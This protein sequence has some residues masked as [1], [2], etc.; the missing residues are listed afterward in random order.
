M[1]IRASRAVLGALL[2]ITTACNDAVSNF[3]STLAT[4]RL[5]NDTD[6]PLSIANN[7]IFD[8]ANARLLFGQ[9]STCL[10]VDP[11]ATTMPA[12]TVTNRATGTS[13]AFTPSLV[14]GENVT[15]IAFGASVGTVQL[16]ALSNRYV[17]ATD[18]AGLRFFNGV[19]T[20]GSLLMRRGG[21]ALTPFVAP[22]SA[23]DFVSVPTDSARIAF[24][25]ASTVVLDAGLLAFPQGQNSTVVVGPP[26]AGT[27]PLRF[28][29]AQ[30]C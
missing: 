18:D 12:V 16:A 1:M 13:I 11:S 14:A 8:S 2:L 7:G 6:I 20:I 5:V 22:G 3:V 23:S 19:P 4:V 26:A 10:S 21:S 9:S 28:F 24:S 17:P 27:S 15:V 29:T 30:G 25:T